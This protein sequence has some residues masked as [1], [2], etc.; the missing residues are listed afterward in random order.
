MKATAEDVVHCMCDQTAPD[1]HAAV[2]HTL[3][4]R[5]EFGTQV[6]KQRQAQPEE[7]NPELLA[8][9]VCNGAFV[10]IMS[11]YLWKSLPERWWSLELGGVDHPGRRTNSHANGF[12]P[13][14]LNTCCRDH[15]CGFF[16]QGRSGF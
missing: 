12:R 16:Q 7:A 1:F 9:P 10:Y 11:H 15:Q 8:V 5:H 13:A 14:D 2:N 4:W 3:P 6:P